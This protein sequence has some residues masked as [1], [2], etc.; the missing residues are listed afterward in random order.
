MLSV[1][2]CHAVIV[3]IGTADYWQVI[4]CVLIIHPEKPVSRNVRRDE[5]INRIFFLKKKYFIS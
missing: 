1:S 3:G 4:Q 5:G 2:I